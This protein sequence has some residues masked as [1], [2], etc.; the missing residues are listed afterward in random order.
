M[1]ARLYLDTHPADLLRLE[2]LK[3]A[4]L[5]ILEGSEFTN[6]RSA[7]AQTF[8]TLLSSNALLKDSYSSPHSTV[9]T[10]VVEPLK[11]QLLE[12]SA[13]LRRISRVEGFAG[14]DCKAII[15]SGDQFVPH[16]RMLY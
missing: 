7:E 9:N 15:Q 2:F 11:K 1:L 13:L 16:C 10:N 5:E 12:D 4:A 6:A 8:G 3:K 14:V